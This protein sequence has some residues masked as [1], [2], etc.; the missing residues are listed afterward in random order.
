MN[1]RDL[2]AELQAAMNE[3]LAGIV[4]PHPPVQNDAETRSRNAEASP[5]SPW[6]NR[7]GAEL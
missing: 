2:W 1:N 7:N 6:P 5:V 3:Q 4:P